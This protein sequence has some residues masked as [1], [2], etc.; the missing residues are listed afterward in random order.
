MV[1]TST[2][3]LVYLALLM[4]LSIVLTRIASITIPFEGV[5]T[6]RL[7]L[8]QL[9]IMLAGLLFGPYWGFT[10]GILADIIGFNLN[11]L[12]IY[13]PQ[14][15]L[16]AG[17]HG[18]LPPLIIRLF[19]KNYPA[20]SLIAAIALTQIVTSLLLTPYV[21]KTAFG[22]PWLI[23]MPGRLVSQLLIIPAYILLTKKI[24][25]ALNL[26]LFPARK[27]HISYH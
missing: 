12:G 10:T 21:L 16:I 7:G 5:I 20:H 3:R 26:P 25:T 8:G 17:L 4:S 2:K 27:G 19:G 23:S 11:P 1:Y 15:S 18:L 6:L 14:F 22:I 9:P 13:L 24:I